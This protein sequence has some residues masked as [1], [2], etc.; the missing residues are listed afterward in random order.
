V[1]EADSQ[2][3]IRDN[4]SYIDKFKGEEQKVGA[5]G[6]ESVDRDMGTDKIDSDEEDLMNGDENGGSETP[7]DGS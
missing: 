1:Y 7:S 4:L 3:N 6:L 5:S 2:K